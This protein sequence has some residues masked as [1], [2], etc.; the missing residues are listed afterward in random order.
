MAKQIKALVKPRIL[1]WARESLNLSLPDAAKKI[2]VKASK[3][4]EWESGAASPTVGQLRKAAAV[5][6]RPLA[7]FFLSSH[8]EILTL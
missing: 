6:K 7:V 4:T 8:P 3:L 2:G 5:Y 1:R